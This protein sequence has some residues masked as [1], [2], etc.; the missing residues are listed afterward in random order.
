MSCITEILKLRDQDGLVK[1]IKG[2]KVFLVAEG[3]GKYKGYEFIVTF[4]ELGHRCGYVAI[5]PEHPCSERDLMYHG[6]TDEVELECHGGVTFYSRKHSLRDLLKHQCDDVWVGF[7]CAHAYDGKDLDLL[8]KYYGEDSDQI[9]FYKEYPQYQ[10]SNELETVRS[11]AYV[12][13]HCRK[14]I[15]QLIKAA[16]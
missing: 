5:P 10:A 1:V 3:G 14:I 11:Y 15:N 7:D 4:T 6:V 8:R 2:D 13:N 16:A 9:K 12:V